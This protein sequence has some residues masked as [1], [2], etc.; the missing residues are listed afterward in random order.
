MT[1]GRDE[2][3]R[4]WMARALELAAAGW[5][6]VHPNP[7]VGAVVVRDDVA[8]GE[9][10]HREFGGPH[11]EVEALAA[12]GDR[13]RGATLYVT[14]EPCSHHGKTPPCT[15]AILDH[16][17][18]R[19]VYAVP[20]PH[21]EA[22]GGGDLLRRAGVEVTAGVLEDRGRTRNA[23]FLHPIERGRPF[24]AVKLALT[25]DGYI[26]R[27]EWERTAVTGPEAQEAVHRLRG[28][29]D[30]VLVGGRTAR[31]DDPAL[32]VRLGPPPRVPP[33]RIVADP[34][35]RLPLEGAL[36]RTAAET[37]VWALIGPDAPGDRVRGL[38]DRGVETVPVDGGPAGL[39][40]RAALDSLMERGVRTILCEGGGRLAAGLLEVERVDRLYLFFAPVV[41]GGGVP[42]FPGGGRFDGRRVEHRAVGVDTLITIDR[43]Q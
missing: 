38:E 28:G 10:A 41:W 21:P 12:A 11:A 16:G 25:L 34:D 26:A 8:V 18:A 15:S 7:L 42:G 19:V 2:A 22:G 6:R 40:L 43:S 31:V 3:D 17:V 1:N 33:I 24:V 9:G 27:K 13:A 30:A 29:Y 14:L 37:P 36:V 4:R 5:G 32:D 39:D 23:L 20:D 35:A